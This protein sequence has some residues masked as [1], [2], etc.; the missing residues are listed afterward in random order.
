MKYESG[1]KM[2]PFLILYFSGVGNTKAIAEQMK[3]Y[4]Y[5]DYFDFSGERRWMNAIEIVVSKTPRFS[6]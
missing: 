6:E 5:A 1:A 2:K 3:N 4:A